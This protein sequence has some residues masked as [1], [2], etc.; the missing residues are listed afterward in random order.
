MTQLFVFSKSGDSV[1]CFYFQF[2]C[3][4]KKNQQIW[5]CF[6]QLQKLFT[7][8]WTN[9][10]I[11][12]KFNFWFKISWIYLIYKNSVSATVF[13]YLYILTPLCQVNFQNKSNS[14][15]IC[16]NIFACLFSV[17]NI[18]LSC[19]EQVC[20]MKLCFKRYFSHLWAM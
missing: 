6:Y 8:E 1:Y 11:C 20:L 18:R 10:L 9:F 14:I 13:S 12:I 15:C 3:L 7:F 19:H 17:Y 16:K 4:I 5:N 2:E